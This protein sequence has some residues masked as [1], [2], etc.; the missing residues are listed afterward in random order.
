MGK[1]ELPLE[2]EC[3]LMRRMRQEK[4][5]VPRGFPRRARQRQNSSIRSAGARRAWQTRLCVSVPDL[6]HTVGGQ[7]LIELES[8][9][10][11]SEGVRRK[12]TTMGKA[13]VQEL[14]AKRGV[15]DFNSTGR[16]G[17]NRPNMTGHIVELTAHSD[18]RQLINGR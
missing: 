7:G 12:T 4:E 17:R 16:L 15:I 9:D 13:K 1:D 5:L 3:D 10:K 11:T 18:R 8:R 6:D 2:N 14:K